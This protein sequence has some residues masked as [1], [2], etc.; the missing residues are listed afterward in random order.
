MP[1]SRDY[2]LS[3]SK[4][5]SSLLRILRQHVSSSIFYFVVPHLFSI[6]FHH[7]LLFFPVLDPLTHLKLSHSSSK[8]YKSN[9]SFSTIRSLD[10][11]SI[12]DLSLLSDSNFDFLALSETWHESASSP[13]HISACSP[14]Y[15]FLELARASQKP[16]FHFFFHSRKNLSFLKATFSFS[17]TSHSGFK[18]F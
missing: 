15:S 6:V 5:S 2:L 1:S 11:K 17:K 4:F 7:K 12:K 14:S 3:F 8:L 16:F 10:K 13:S 18:S 9:I